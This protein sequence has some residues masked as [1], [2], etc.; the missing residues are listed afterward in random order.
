MG[1]VRLES[2]LPGTRFRFPGEE[3]V[4]TLDS[5]T[6]TRAVVHTGKTTT[7]IFSVTDKETGEVKNVTVTKP[8]IKE[9][10]PG[11]EVEVVE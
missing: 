2:L 4:N 10:A 5:I 8:L 1:L 11:A 6:F 3:N 7:R 9:V